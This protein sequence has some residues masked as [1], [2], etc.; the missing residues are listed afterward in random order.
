MN[1][2]ASPVRVDGFAGYDVVRVLLGLL[3]LTTAGLKGCQLAGG[4]FARLALV[5]D[6]GGSVAPATLSGSGEILDDG[7]FVVLE[8]AEWNGKRFPLLDYIDI[9]S[10]LAQGEWIVILYHFDCARRREAIPKYEEVARV[11]SVQ[12]ISRRLA[13][14]EAPP[15]G[16]N[17]GCRV[18][19]ALMERCPIPKSGFSLRPLRCSFRMG[20]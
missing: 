3:S 12:D 7:Q 15:H 13:L 2:D 19:V 4:R 5:S 6:R 16:K 20:R 1:G 8:P 10:Q 9:G 11:L 18:R 14:T 17:G